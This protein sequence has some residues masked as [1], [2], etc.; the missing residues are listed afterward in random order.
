MDYNVYPLSVCEVITICLLIFSLLLTLAFLFYRSLLGLIPL[1]PIGFLIWKIIIEEK[2]KKRKRQLGIQFR[3]CIKAV[4]TA[5]KA[6]YSVENAFVGSIDDMRLMFGEEAFIVKELRMMVRGLANNMNLED[7]LFYL[8]E[9][10][11][12]DNIIQFAEVFQIAKRG[13]G[14]IS[15]IMED[16]IYLIEK[17][18]ETDE[19][20]EVVISA[21]KFEMVIME[22][23]PFGIIIYISF[24]SPGYFDCLYHNVL[25]VV[26]MTICL[27]AYVIGFILSRK[28]VKIEG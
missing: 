6:G 8:G 3:D 1:L 28:I 18:I 23:V 16:T 2:I 22:T 11:G 5:V 24:S 19:E 25:G 7:Q 20:I 26:I 17:K 12:I 10:S 27:V 21:K 4:L 9:R 14:N 15:Q 13:G